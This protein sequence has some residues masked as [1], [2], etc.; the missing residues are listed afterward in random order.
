MT[1]FKKGINTKT[2]QELI[3]CI[4]EKAVFMSTLEGT[5]Y[6][7]FPLAHFNDSTFIE[8]V[9]FP[10][11]YEK[12]RL[13]FHQRESQKKEQR[14]LERAEARRKESLRLYEERKKEVLFVR[15]VRNAAHGNAEVSVYRRY[16]MEN[17]W[18]GSEWT[19]DNSSPFEEQYFLEKE[20]AFDVSALQEFVND[21]PVD[22]IIEQRTV[23]AEEVLN[24][25]DYEDM[26]NLLECYSD[27]VDEDYIYLSPRY[28]SLE[29]CILA[30]WSWHTYIG[31]DQK[32]YELRYAY[33]S[34]T[35]E[36]LHQNAD[37]T[38]R[39]GMRVSV[40][41]RPEEI[42]GLTT[43]ELREELRSRMFNDTWKWRRES[44]KLI[45]FVLEEF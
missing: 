34:E 35:E 38:G 23:S 32:F 3:A 30:F 16:L 5:I 9:N 7:Q 42:E 27:V 29:G 41:M 33:D 37:Y 14:E 19:T 13:S 36:I 15:S 28:E 11:D 12:Q 1:T 31:Y 40:I 39:R 24:I 8:E 26:M 21:T 4:E 10:G 43:E 44:E 45:E 25:T 6:K 20:H 17:S 22:V 2:G 18:D